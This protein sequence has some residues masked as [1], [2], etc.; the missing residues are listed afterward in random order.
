MRLMQA[1]LC[2]VMGLT[3][4]MLMAAEPEVSPINVVTRPLIAG[5]WAMPIGN[6]GCTE[7][8]NF[9]E[10]GEFFIRSAE[11]RVTGKYEYDLPELGEDKLPLLTIRI[12]HDNLAAYCAGSTANQT[13]AVQQQFIK[14][15]SP[16][17]Q[18]QFCSKADGSS[19]EVT[20]A[21]VLP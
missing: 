9:K 8:Y 14:W 19:C 11:E 12:E 20:L 16:L 17:Y 4:A 15:L 3:S 6:T 10:N 2:G 21:K 7:Y 18:I 1:M 5:L 13:D